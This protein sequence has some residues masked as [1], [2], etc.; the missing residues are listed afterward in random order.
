MNPGSSAKN[1]APNVELV[2]SWPSRAASVVKGRFSYKYI[3]DIIGPLNLLMICKL[4]P[5]SYHLYIFGMGPQKGY[6][7]SKIATLL[8]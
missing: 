1:E 3:D 2:N 5:E 7:Y 8:T 6:L 4:S